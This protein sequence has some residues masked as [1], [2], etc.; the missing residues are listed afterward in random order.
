MHSTAKKRNDLTLEENVEVIR[1]LQN[2]N[3]ERKAADK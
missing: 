2:G 1:F 3:S